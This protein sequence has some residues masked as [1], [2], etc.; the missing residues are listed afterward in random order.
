MLDRLGNS[1][2]EEGLFHILP[3]VRGRVYRF[4]QFQQP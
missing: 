4:E 1:P 3:S 2:F